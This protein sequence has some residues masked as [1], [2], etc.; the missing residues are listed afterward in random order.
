MMMMMMVYD[1]VFGATDRGRV[2]KTDCC[3][4]EKVSLKVP[5]YWICG[6]WIVWSRIS[7][8]VED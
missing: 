4:N 1:D 7:L 2:K 8:V 6:G 3:Y 5:Q